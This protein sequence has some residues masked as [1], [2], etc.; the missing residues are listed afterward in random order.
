MNHKTKTKILISSA[1]AVALSAV[2][3]SA[4]AMT[5]PR[6]DMPR[7]FEAQKM[8]HFSNPLKITNPYFPVSATGHSISMGI[9]EGKVARSEAMLLP[10]IRTITWAGGKTQ[11]RV[12]LY[13]AYLDGHLAETAYDFYAQ[14][15]DGGVY[16]FGE[17][18]TNFKNGQVI[19]HDGSWVAGKNGAPPGLIMPAKPEVGLVFNPENLPGVVFET[20]RVM[21]LSENTIAP[22]GPITAGVLISETLM[23][24]SVEQKVYAAG[25]GNVEARL[26][27]GNERMI[28]FNRTNATPGEVP[29][30]LQIIEAQAETI[31][32]KV[33]SGD[34][35]NITAAMATV[36]QQWQSYQ[37][38]AAKDGVPQAFQDTLIEVLK[39]LQSATSSKTDR[40]TLQ[41]AND[42]SAAVVDIYTVFHP[43]IPSDLGRLDMLERQVVL[44]VATKNW[45][46]ATDSRAKAGVIW[47]RLKPF[48]M[49]QGGAK[50][51]TQFD[52]NLAAQASGLVRKDGSTITSK[53]KE[54][55]EI[56]DALEKLY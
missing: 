44:D 26:P 24:G 11:V 46:A 23:D 41:A 43:R 50:L 42:M 2:A 15:D 30:A 51:A 47:A 16:Y 5:M 12:I 32:D 38:S 28:L 22:N 33:S 7:M 21:S 31:I 37:P 54:G 8:P 3:R 14:A 6:P 49:T 18:V 53:A 35:A 17:E 45:A 4:P 34:W 29:N 25:F 36:E 13:L 10:E 48:I 9:E 55:L 56:V 27:D 1:V 20:D 52:A 39:R 40:A 19:N